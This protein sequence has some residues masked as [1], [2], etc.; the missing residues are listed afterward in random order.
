YYVGA[1]LGGLYLDL[2]WR[3]A[4]WVGV[5][6]GS[7]LTLSVTLGTALWMVGRERQDADLSVE[8]FTQEV[9]EKAV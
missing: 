9:V 1:T 6:T 5:V 2:F 7:L 4:G 3:W 8:S